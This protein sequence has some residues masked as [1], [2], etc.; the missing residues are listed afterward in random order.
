MPEPDFPAATPGHLI[1]VDV[2]AH[3]T[4]VAVVRV[5]GEVDMATAPV[6]RQAVDERIAGQESFVVDMDGVDFLSSAGLAVLVDT[7][8]KTA[9]HELKWAVVAARP[10][11][12]RPLEITG[13]L[14]MLPIHPTVDDA[15]AALG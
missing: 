11:V 4:G 15:L 2:V 10:T 1:G 7:R 13:L 14:G 12:I 8:E 9:Q 3:P 6:F 5:T